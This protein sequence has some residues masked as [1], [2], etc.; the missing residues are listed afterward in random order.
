LVEKLVKLFNTEEAGEARF[1]LA[2]SNPFALTIL[3]SA[4]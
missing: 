4:A 1:V 2:G 3:F